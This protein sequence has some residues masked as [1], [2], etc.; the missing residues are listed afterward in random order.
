MPDL[1]AVVARVVH[2]DV[3]AF[4]RIVEGTNRELVRVAA[5]IVGGVSDAE[6]VVQDAYVKAYRSMVAG[7]FDGRSSVKTWLYRIVSRTAV[8]FLRAKARRPVAREALDQA[9]AR[10]GS[11]E[12]HLAL[13]E[14]SDWLHVLPPEQRAAAVLKFVEGFSSKEAAELL[15]CSEGAVEQRLVR[16]R[17]TLRAK[18]EAK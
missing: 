14:L 13:A 11:P 15:G 17:A 1:E 7:Q 10:S 3:Q 18:L 12:V 6:D 16:A 2:G 4:G 9:P 8:D 5:R